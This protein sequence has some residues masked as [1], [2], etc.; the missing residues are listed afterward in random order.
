[1]TYR[2]E[3][4][5]TYK[6]FQNNL[7][8]LVIQNTVPRLLVI[9]NLLRQQIRHNISIPTAV[10]GPSKRGQYPHLDSGDLHKSIT[11]WLD[12]RPRGRTVLGIKEKIVWI[13]TH[14]DYGIWHEFHGRSFFRRS[15]HECR[16]AIQ[17]IFGKTGY[18]VKRP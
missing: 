7:Q 4:K 3:V 12:D 14:I 2:Q 17:H 6:L 5:S 16:P 13:G 1:M 8:T 18:R 11:Y 10:Y 15:F 9:G